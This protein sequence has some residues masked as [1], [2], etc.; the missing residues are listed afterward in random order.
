MW[1]STVMSQALI[2]KVLERTAVPDDQC[3]T[4]ARAM[5][6]LFDIR[7]AFQRPEFLL[8]PAR[9]ES[10]LFNLHAVANQL[11]GEEMVG[12]FHDILWDCYDSN[13]DRFWEEWE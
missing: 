3:A 10:V 13:S 5:S 9:T 12:R 1:V 7:Q 4:S 8:H 6:V 11:E 2:Q